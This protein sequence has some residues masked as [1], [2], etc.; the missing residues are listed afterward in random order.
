MIFAD[1]LYLFALL[2]PDDQW[3][4][5]AAQIS[6]TSQEPI[7]TTGRVLMETG[8]GLAGSA[9]RSMFA[10][11]VRRF[12]TAQDVEVV[13]AT[14]EWFERGLALYETRPDKEWSLTDCISFLVMRERGVTDALTN[15]HHFEQAGFRILL[16]S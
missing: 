6:R 8:N 1:T 14:M 2:S 5:R 12:R 13:P 16:K 4:R 10:A 3:H 15:D 11:F 9:N 7:L